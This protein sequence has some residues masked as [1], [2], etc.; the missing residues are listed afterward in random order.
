[1]Q[2]RDKTALLLDAL[3]GCFRNNPALLQEARVQK[4]AGGSRQPATCSPRTGN[5]ATW[6][7]R[8]KATLRQT[9]AKRHAGHAA[10]HTDGPGALKSQR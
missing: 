8:A 6:D 7:K 2:K 5:V 4:M 10:G 1:M 3:R 9:T